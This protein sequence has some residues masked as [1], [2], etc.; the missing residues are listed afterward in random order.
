VT[1]TASITTTIIIIINIVIS[2]TTIVCDRKFVFGHL[3]MID[4][5]PLPLCL[6]GVLCIWTHP[7]LLL[8][9]LKSFL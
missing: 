6:S 3:S 7:V 8:S 5:C 2:F 1:C 9:P 4:R